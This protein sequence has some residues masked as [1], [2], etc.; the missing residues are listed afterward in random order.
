MLLAKKDYEGALAMS[1][2]AVEVGP[3]SVR[4]SSPEGRCCAR[5][6]TSKRRPTILRV[7]VEQDESNAEAQVLLAWAL[8]KQGPAYLDE[9]ER[10]LRAAIKVDDY[11]G[12]RKDLATVL[13]I[14][15]DQ[16]AA[17]E[18]AQALRGLGDGDGA[19]ADDLAMA[20]WCLYGLGRFDEA[21]KVYRKSLRIAPGSVE[22]MFD[23]GLAVLCQG[24]GDAAHEEYGRAV[25]QAERK[26]RLRRR[27]LFRVALI[28]LED[29]RRVRGLDGDAVV[30][31]HQLLKDALRQLEAKVARGGAGDSRPSRPRRRLP[32]RRELDHLVGTDT[33]SHRSVKLVDSRKVVSAGAL[34]T[35]IVTL[36]APEPSAKETS[37]AKTVPCAPC[38][39]TVTSRVS[40]RVP[41]G[42]SLALTLAT[43]S[44]F[45]SALSFHCRARDGWSCCLATWMM[46]A[47]AITNAALKR[48]RARRVSQPRTEILVV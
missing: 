12:Y 23:L 30:A 46:I 14:R 1:D 7:A 29:A 11:A 28:D 42:S 20:G 15:G 16:T 44:R 39:S 41:G 45:R 26:P 37:L 4:R 6:A 27:G 35:S 25:G 32:S 22:T 18:F 8:R 36:T 2:R 21:V 34:L 43:T 10:A 38:L 24:Q 3:S 48:S 19:D 47:R 9:A 33:A 5:S 13:W 40:A 31:C 17:K